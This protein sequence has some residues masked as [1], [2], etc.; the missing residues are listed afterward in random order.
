MLADG[1]SG[2]LLLACTLLPQSPPAAQVDAGPPG[3][4][5]AARSRQV[6]LE[7][8]FLALPQPANLRRYLSLL[9]EEPRRSGTPGAE[10]SAKFVAEQLKSFGLEVQIVVFY[11]YLPE[12]K[13]I[14]LKV[15]EPF[16]ALMPT[17]EPGMAID[18]DSFRKDVVIA[19]SA[20][21]APGE[22]TGDL[23]YVNY[24]LPTDYAVLE[25]RGIEV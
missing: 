13:T 5:P 1:P 4:A 14:E 3:F 25:A 20:Y 7:D 15:L 9:T 24:G 10:S 11:G 19:H 23:I 8:R 16:E 2:L 18:K 17:P 6:T 22:A 12:P 21:A